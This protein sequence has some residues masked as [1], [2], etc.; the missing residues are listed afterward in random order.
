MTIPSPSM[1]HLI[2]C[3]R[4]ESYTP[5]ERYR[6]EAVLFEDIAAAYQKAVLA[7]YDAGCRY[8]QLDDTSW[9]EFCDEDKREAYAKRGFD[10]DRIAKEYVKVLNKV[11]AVKPKDMVITMHI[12]RG[13]F[14]STWFS[15]G[16]YGPIAKTLFA[17]CLVDGFFLEYDT[18]RAGDFNPLHHIKDQKV[19][20]GLV[21]SKSA[22]LEN[23]EAIKRRIKKQAP[24]FPWISWPLARNAALLP[25][26]KA[27]SS[28]K[29]TSGRSS[30]LS[31]ALPVKSGPMPIEFRLS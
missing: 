17:H 23:S 3:V 26:K 9:G 28:R 13:N 16:G 25:R 10:L 2:A 22:D 21:T 18:D 6:D 8:L 19:V 4:T 24:W 14:R 5:I 12:C 27:I 31:A 11:L 29:K 15:S 7:F 1:L 20:L 30:P